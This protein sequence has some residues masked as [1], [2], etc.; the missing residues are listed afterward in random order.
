MKKRYLSLT[1]AILSV[2][3]VVTGTALQSQQQRLAGKLIR[4]HVVAN[5]DSDYDQ[6]VKLQVRDAVLEKTRALLQGGQDDPKQALAEGLVEI[7]AA[8]EAKLRQL[9]CGEP[10]RVTLGK[11]A[12]PTREYD[13]FTLPAGV[14]ES[15]RVSIGEADG[16]NWWCVVFP[17]ICLTASMDELEQAAETAGLT[18]D[19][20]RLITGEDEGVVLKFKTLELLQKLK[21]I[22]FG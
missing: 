5:S 8:A 20:L 11:E 12:F 9:G 21:Q 3:M 14:Y 10:V 2:L 19:E 4:L 17:S 22:I 15:L 7:E 6:A 1:L 18:Q 13:T 16:H